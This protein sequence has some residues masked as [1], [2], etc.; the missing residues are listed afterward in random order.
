MLRQEFIQNP[1]WVRSDEGVVFGVC[2][3][4]GESSGIGGP[5]IRCLFLVML[6]IFGTGLLVYLSLALCLPKR[7]KVQEAYRKKILG[8]C[9]RLGVKGELEVPFVRFLFFFSLFLSLGATIFIY[10]T[11]HFILDPVS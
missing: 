4:L 10:L 2:R 7:S 11:L 9:Y 8:V 5:L 3:G 6:L 1:F